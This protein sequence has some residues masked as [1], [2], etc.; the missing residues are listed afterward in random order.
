MRE[1]VKDS[2]TLGLRNSPEEN[3]GDKGSLFVQPGP[4]PLTHHVGTAQI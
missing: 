3:Q 1:L 4:P 2:W